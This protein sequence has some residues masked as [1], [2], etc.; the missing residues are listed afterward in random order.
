MIDVTRLPSVYPPNVAMA[1]GVRRMYIVRGDTPRHTVRSP[2]LHLL[3]DSLVD[4][5]VIDRCSRRQ[6]RE[7]ACSLIDGRVDVRALCIEH[8][9]NPSHE[10]TDYLW[11]GLPVTYLIRMD[12]T[13]YSEGRCPIK[14]G[15]SRSSTARMS[16]M[17][18]SSPFPP[19]R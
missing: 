18:T 11:G 6:A 8:G 14:I 12:V 15:R 16:A 1:D 7:L 2:L 9:M 17:R 10:V 19:A 4:A 13:A 3:T 5:G